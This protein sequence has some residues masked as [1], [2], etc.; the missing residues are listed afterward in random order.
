L[1]HPAA[2]IREAVISPD[3]DLLSRLDTHDSQDTDS[4]LILP[5][6]CPHTHWAIW[7]KRVR[8]PEFGRG[9]SITQSLATPLRVEHVPLHRNAGKAMNR[10]LL[11]SQPRPKTNPIPMQ[12]WERMEWRKHRVRRY[13][14]SLK[15]TCGTNDTIHKTLRPLPLDSIKCTY[16]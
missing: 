4:S 14:R 13:G 6:I 1:L 15:V 3:R 7:T 8:P 2:E 12:T 9:S 11:I 16:L 5:L 10:S